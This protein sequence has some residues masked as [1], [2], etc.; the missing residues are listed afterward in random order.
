MQLANICLAFSKVVFLLLQITSMIMI[1]L[2]LFFGLMCLAKVLPATTIVIYITPDFVIMAADSKGVFTNAKTNKQSV[3]SVS[4]IYKSGNRYFSVAGLA[5]NT[6]RSLNIAAIANERLSHTSNLETAIDQL[7]LDIKEA[8]LTYLSNQKKNNPTLYRNNLSE[9]YVTSIGLVTI[10]NNRPYTHLIG[11]A[12]SDKGQLK[13]SVEEEVY[14][15]ANSKDAVYYL[16]TSGEINRY[17]NSIQTNK[18][19]PVEFVE[20]LM[21]LQIDK[22]PQLVAGPVDILKLTN[23]R[24]TW[25]KRKKGTPVDLN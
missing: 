11:F 4:K 10:Q 15:G 3:E 13:I 17:M 5:L 19:E 18:Y 24:A 6:T 25:V 14:K 1:R 22:T 16:G 2:L 12:A 8:L 7:K 20:R 23:R 21:N 9:K